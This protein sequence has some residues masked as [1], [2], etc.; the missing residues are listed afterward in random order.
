MTTR[1]RAYTVSEAA[2]ALGVSEWLVRE[3]VRRG[4]ICCTRIGRRIIIPAAVIDAM[5]ST[6][7]VDEDFGASR[8]TPTEV[9]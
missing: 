9:K 5:L 4:E 8:S 6:P 1:K 3:A 2:E 7:S